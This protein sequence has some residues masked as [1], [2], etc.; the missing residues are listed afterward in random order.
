MSTFNVKDA[1]RNI[2]RKKELLQSFEP[3]SKDLVKNLDDRLRVELTYTS[4]AIEGNTLS[5]QETMLVVDEGLSVPWKTVCEIQ[6][7]KNHHKALD[8]VLDLAKKKTKIGEITQRDILNI[9]DFI[10][11]GIDNFNA[12]KYRSVQVR[13]SGSEHIPPNAMKVPDL[14]DDLEKWL[15]TTDTSDFIKVACDF[16]FKFVIIHPFIDGNG[17]VARLLFNLVLL[18]GGYPL[19][20]IE[21]KERTK[22][23]QSWEKA[24]TQADYNDYYQ[25]MY[26]AVER[27]LDLYLE[28]IQGVA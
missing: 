15:Q 1:I 3:L 27:S 21:K 26:G 8:Y 2:Q 25:V 6:E 19:S 14:M 12:G 22:Y 7:A 20:F 4:N 18:I 16:H 11:A 5:R 17:R 9:H 23:I 13:I 28:Q 24:N 10:L